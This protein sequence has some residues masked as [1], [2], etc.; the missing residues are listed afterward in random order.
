[1]EVQYDKNNLVNLSN[2]I[3]KYFDI[4]TYHPTIL[5]IDKILNKN[6]YK[7][8]IL[9]VCDG[10]GYYNLK[11]LLGKDSF[12]KSCP[13]LKIY[14]VFPPTTTAATTTLLSG[15]TP[16]AHHWFGWN[17][18]FKDSN[19]TISLFL[20]KTKEKEEIPKINITDRKYMKYKNI[21]ELINENSKNSAYFAYPFSSDNKCMDIDD[22]CE[23]IKE[24][25]KIDSKKF[26]YAYIENPDKLMHQYGIYSKIVKEEVKK[27]N[28]K[29]EK[30]SKEIKDS[31]ILVTADHGLISTKYI[32][33]KTDLRE[34][35]D[36]LERTTSLE[37]RCVGIKLKNNVK[38]EDFLNLYNQ[39]LINYFKLLSQEEVI[40]KKI[41]GN[42]DSSYLRDT[43][44]DYLLIATKNISI[45]YNETEP[46]FKATHAGLT[47]KELTVPLLII[48]C[49]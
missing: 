30:L 8:V 21:V 1:M 7:N 10:L 24:L 31:L 11:K 23:R 15:L 48:D 49:K 37:P 27:I 2:S 6:H 41:F 43:I 13:M 33:L 39:K 28:D 35:Y 22:V 18:Y 17:M 36:M 25:S 42:E 3:L 9:F 46:K 12:L 45:N 32:T 29:I 26:I 47:K 14:S 16:A 34:L 44:G 38:K 5:E 4:K 19:E 20:N 40:T